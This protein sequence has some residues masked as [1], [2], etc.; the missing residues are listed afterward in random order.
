ERAAR[1]RKLAEVNE[2]FPRRPDRPGSVSEEHKP[3]SPAEGLRAALEFA[4]LDA[5]LARL[6]VEEHAGC[7]KEKFPTSHDGI[8]APFLDGLL[9][10]RA[11]R[12]AED[13]PKLAEPHSSTC[14]IDACFGNSAGSGGH[15][16]WAS[17]FR[18]PPDFYA[19]HDRALGTILQQRGYPFSTFLPTL[20]PVLLAKRLICTWSWLLHAGLRPRGPVPCRRGVA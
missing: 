15:R 2:C 11:E 20:N 1:G 9:E 18:R 10:A 14:C 19:K 13:S 6:T 16:C 4:G 7:E 8:R 3:L 5:G 17:A 12:K